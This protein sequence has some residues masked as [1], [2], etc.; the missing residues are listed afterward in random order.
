MICS[1]DKIYNTV[2]LGA[3]LH[4]IGK[5]LGRGKFQVLDK[6]QH[7]K[8]SADF[9]SAFSLVFGDVADVELLQVLVMKHHEDSRNFSDDFLVQSI[10]DPHVRTLAT[11]VSKADNLSSSERGRRSEQYQDYKATPMFSVLERVNRT[12]DNNLRLRFHLQPLLADA[13]IFPSEF[14]AYAPGEVN[15]FLQQFGN[16]F[17]NLFTPAKAQ[18]RWASFDQMVTHIS[19]IVYKYT[20][21]L[22]SNTQ[23]AVPDISLFDHLRTTAAIA[24]C[25]YQYHT[26]T[27]TLNE[28]SV[29]DTDEPRFVLCAGDLSG[30]QSYIFDIATTGAGGVA[31]RLRARSLYVQLCSEVAATKILKECNLPLWNILMN[32]GGRFYILLPN[33]APVLERL[34]AVRREFDSWFLAYLNGELR[35]NL[36]HVPFNDAGFAAGGSVGGFSQVL[37]ELSTALNGVKQRQLLSALQCNEGWDEDAF[38]LPLS[39]DGKSDCA[40]CHKFPEVT[41]GLCWHCQRDLMVG[42]ELPKSHYL[43]IFDKEVSG[44]F[45]VLGYYVKLTD[46]PH[47]PGP[48]ALVMKLNFTDLADIWQYPAVCKHIARHVPQAEGATLTF[49]DIAARSEG[50]PL[51]GY[52]KIDLDNLGRT[53]VFGFK[54]PSD[55][56]DTVSRQATMSRLLDLFFT[57]WVEHLLSSEFPDCYVIFSGGDDMLVVGPWDRMLGLSLGVRRAFAKFTGCPVEDS[58]LTLSAGLAILKPDYPVARAVTV[59]NEALEM[60]KDKGR[61][62]ITILGTTLPWNEWADAFKEWQE[63]RPLIK[64]AKGVSSAFLHSLVAF[65]GMWQEYVNEKNVAALRF[66]PLLSYNVRRNLDG[67]KHPELYSWVDQ[68]LRWPPGDK[69]KKMLGRLSLLASLLLYS[70][71]GGD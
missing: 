29:S 63:L 70:R 33:I 20:W 36:A 11:L 16:E 53:F 34:D 6:G 9:I 41:D 26:F 23:E 31:R 30:I 60:S 43:A 8:F 68:L 32:S 45:P 54:R 21:A 61:N 47:F 69:E 7:P 1:D 62:R 37:G 19:N 52:L 51:L 10:K 50:K 4:D 67:R 28:R 14:Q 27:N 56:H 35:L 5:F 58:R 42:S 64:E 57:G 12:D 17:K 46:S 39:F 25:L 55:S 18:R 44:A 38:V 49:E 59:V 3:F 48:P 15:K 13:R 24:A 40:S 65:G 71:K 66:H 2:V 22:P